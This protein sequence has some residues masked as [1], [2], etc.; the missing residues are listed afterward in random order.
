MESR[1]VGEP[2]SG[3]A[4]ERESGGDGERESGGRERSESPEGVVARHCEA[5]RSNPKQSPMAGLLLI[6][7]CNERQSRMAGLLLTSGPIW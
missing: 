3:G 2:G 7:Q 4:G 6:S 1:S 5:L